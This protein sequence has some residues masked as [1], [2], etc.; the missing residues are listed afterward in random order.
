MDSLPA[1]FFV[2][3]M[4]FT[5]HVFQDQYPSIDPTSPSLSLA[6]KVAVIT[7]A[8][9]GIGA[10]GMVPAFAKAGVKGLALLATSADKL[11]EVEA[12]VAKIN[13]EVKVL[14]VGVN[15]SD[16]ASVDAAF[17]Q[18]VETFGHADVLVNNAGV[19]TEGEG[20]LI[21]DEDPDAWWQ[22][23]EVNGKGTFLV[24]RAFLRQ[25]P[26]K[27]HAATIVTLVTGA[28]WQVF[29]TISGYGI[30]KQLAL[31]V[32]AH[33][34]AGY[35]NVTAV[36]LHPGLVDTDMLMDAFRH[37]TLETPALVGGLAVWLSHPHAH[38]LSGRNVASQ[39]SVDDLVAR[40]DEIVS[41]DLLKLNLQGKFGADQ[42]Q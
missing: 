12:E 10:K 35:P 34:A 6:G 28:A 29:P 4:Q 16:K 17:A 5:K 36:G 2:T 22:N 27:D 41:Q 8:S 21:G 1:D 13:P 24:S 32:S 23:F 15:I 19:N 3:S 42:F 7:G 39:W 26:S 9:R 33:I 20:A 11:K 38:F 25:L 40:K 30:S 18:I 37:F 14:R 31:S